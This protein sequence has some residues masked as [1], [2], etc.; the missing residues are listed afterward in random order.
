MSRTGRIMVGD[1]KLLLTHLKAVHSARGRA[2][3]QVG[4][5]GWYRAIVLLP[6]T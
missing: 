5:Q 4:Q 2:D 3:G 6:V 1:E